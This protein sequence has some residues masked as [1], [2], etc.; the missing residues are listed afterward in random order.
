M[1]PD[2]SFLTGV[3]LGV[4]SLRCTCHASDFGFVD[5]IRLFSSRLGT[6]RQKRPELRIHIALKFEAEL[7]NDLITAAQSSV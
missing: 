5:P 6:I 1:T 2:L 3:A 4:L 7:I